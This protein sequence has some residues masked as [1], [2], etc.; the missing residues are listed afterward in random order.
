MGKAGNLFWL[1]FFGARYHTTVPGLEVHN[2]LWSMKW[3]LC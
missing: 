1:R 3:F 2:T